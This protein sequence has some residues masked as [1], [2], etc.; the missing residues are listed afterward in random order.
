MKDAKGHGSNPRGTAPGYAGRDAMGRT[1]TQAIR[2]FDRF[3]K[4]NPKMPNAEDYRTPGEAKVASLASQHGIGTGHLKVQ[5]LDT[6]MAGSPWRTQKRFGN[7]TVAE[8]VAKG[9]RTDGGFMR[10]K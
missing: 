9:M 4:Q 3:P 5:A 6:K 2:D 10:I 7:R 8:T 1:Y